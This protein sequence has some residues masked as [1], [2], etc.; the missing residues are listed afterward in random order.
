MPGTIQMKSSDILYRL[1][2]S[3]ARAIVAGDKVAQ[4]V[5]AVA[6]DCSLLK[7][8]LLV[9]EKNR[10]GWLN[11]KALLKD[12]ST[13]HQCV[14]TGSQ[15][16]AAIY[17]TS[18]TS[19]PPKMAEH[20]HCSLGIKAKMDA[21]SWTGLGTSDIVWTISDTGWILNIL[22]AFLEPWVLGACIFVHLLPK[23][24]PQTVLKLQIST[25]A[26]LLHWRRD[27]SPRDSGELEIQDRTGNPRNLW[28]DRNGTY[29]QSF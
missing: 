4:E 6:S 23:F 22:A 20:S 27:P 26:Q 24:D 18:G 29:L 7:I 17:F 16:S 10:D 11:F 21:D 25:S 5:D 2:A 3:K 19:G 28:P 1:Q 8:K 15:E 9:S 13:I 14:E 12:A